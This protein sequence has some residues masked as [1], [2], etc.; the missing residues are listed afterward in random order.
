MLRQQRRL[1]CRGEACLAL[2]A[3]MT[4]KGEAGLA[5]T[6]QME[7]FFEKLSDLA[8]SGTP[9]VSV[10][11]VDVAGSTPQDRGSKMLV[12]SGGL[13]FGTIGGGKAEFT[14][15][16]RAQSM[17][18]DPSQ[19][20]TLFLEWNLKNDLNMVCGGAVKLFFEAFNLTP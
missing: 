15:I 9:F 3:W 10:T 12:T 7:T 14:A 6:N 16:Q 13:A 8:A 17:L 5:P 11:L 18:S 4:K 1:P 19:D 2:F 20:R